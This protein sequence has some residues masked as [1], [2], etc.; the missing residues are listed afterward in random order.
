MSPLMDFQEYNDNHDS[1]GQFS[2]SGE[3]IDKGRGPNQDQEI[4]AT[5]YSRG[6]KGQREH[7]TVEHN[8]DTERTKITHTVMGQGSSSHTIADKKVAAIHLER[9]YGISHKF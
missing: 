8:T 4:R 7:V 9:T 6:S 1:K 5:T 2:S 3:M